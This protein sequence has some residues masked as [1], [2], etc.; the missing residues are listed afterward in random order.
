MSTRPIIFSGC[1]PYIPILLRK[2]CWFFWTN[3]E[4]KTHTVLQTECKSIIY[5]RSLKKL[6]NYSVMVQNNSFYCRMLMKITIL[7]L[8]GHMSNVIW[9]VQQF[10]DCRP[11]THWC[12]IM[13][14]D[15]YSKSAL[16]VVAVNI[17]TLILALHFN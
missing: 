7:R 3:E 11:L 16:K 1:A 17:V 15:V 13:L 8:C 12:Y 10:C 5:A 4:N 9:H 2:K 14:W 6:W